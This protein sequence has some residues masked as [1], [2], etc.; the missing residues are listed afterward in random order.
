MR[1]STR[2]PSPVI[3]RVL[4][5][6]VALAMGGGAGAVRA[7]GADG[8]GVMA[9]TETGS[10]SGPELRPRWIEPRRGDGPSPLAREPEPELDP[11][12][13]PDPDPGLEP[14]R[15]WRR[16]ASVIVHAV[17]AEARL[18]ASVEGLLEQL[19]AREVE[20]RAVDTAASTDQVRFFHA[21]DAAMARELAV[22][23]EPLFGDV[24][25]RDLTCY[26]PS[27]ESGAL[28]VWLR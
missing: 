11:D 20:R 6:A 25:V 4:A 15:D 9:V 27:P 13:D 23:L 1:Q 2:Q 16:V 12:P 10:V 8:A 14:E 24:G 3:S 28:E 18:A 22:T 19:G 7:E 21:E 5:G 26:R 17:P